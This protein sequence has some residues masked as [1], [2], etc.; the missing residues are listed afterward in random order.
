MLATLALMGVLA[1]GP[2]SRTVAAPT[3]STVHVKDELAAFYADHLAQALRQNGLKVVT[4][5]EMR[6]VLASQRQMQLLGCTGDSS[7]LTELANALGCEMTLMGSIAKLDDSLEVHLK[8]IR[9]PTGVVVAETNLSAVGEKALLETLEGA[10]ARI[11]AGIVSPDQRRSVRAWALL[12]GIAGLAG[13]GVGAFLLVSAQ[14]TY[15][16]LLQTLHAPGDANSTA[17]T[18][19]ASTG[20]LQQTG[21]WIAVGVGIAAVVAALALLLFGGG[22]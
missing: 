12:P 9:A 4:A 6:A 18:S 15:T 14:G 17:A 16:Q 5:S 22:A 1:Q 7:C 8:V 11:A 19:L 20:N 21:G 10:A 2:A 13:V 3:W